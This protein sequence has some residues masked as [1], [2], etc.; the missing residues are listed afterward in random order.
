MKTKKEIIALLITVAR[1]AYDVADGTEHRGEKD[2][3]P[4]GDDM[5][6]MFEAL[7]KLDELPDP[8]KFLSSPGGK[9][10]YWLSQP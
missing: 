10:E 4:N 1:A 9:A 2:H 8:P 6:T 3:R 5:E 7:D